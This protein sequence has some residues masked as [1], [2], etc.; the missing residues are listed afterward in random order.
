MIRMNSYVFW[1][2]L[3]IILACW[4]LI[5]KYQII[6][7]LGFHIVPVA[8]LYSSL[9]IFVKKN[10]VKRFIVK[11]NYQSLIFLIIIN[12]C[13]GVIFNSTISVYHVI[14]TKFLF[15]FLAGIAGIVIWWY[16][17]IIISITD[18][19]FLHK[20][21]KQILCGFGTHT[22]LILCTHYYPLKLLMLVSK[23]FFDF[24]LWHYQSTI[25]SFTISI[26]L[27]LIYAYV[28]TRYDKISIKNS[29]IKSVFG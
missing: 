2:F 1:G 16:L 8:L 21:I 3:G 14:Y 13:F 24:D 9:G 29:I 18:K 7:P 4:I 15:T 6:L 22:V 17:A 27:L 20:E 26:L 23:K 25:K 19:K 5:S 10:S 28:I 11:M 12:I